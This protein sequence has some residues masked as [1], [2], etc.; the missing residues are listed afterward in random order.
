MTRPTIR[1]AVGITLLFAMQASSSAREVAGLVL[2]LPF[3]E[4]KGA[5]VADG[6]GNGNDGKIKGGVK[7]TT[8]KYGGGLQFDGNDGVVEVPDS[9]SLQFTDGLTVAVWIKP[10][11]KGDEWQLLGSKGADAKEF[12]EVLLSPNGFLWMGWMF[13]NAQRIVP[14]QSPK[15]VKPDVW[16][17]VAVAWDPKQFWTVYLDGEPLI[18]YPKQD[19][20]L[21]PNTDPVLIG[22]ELNLKRY[23]NGVMDDWALFNRGLTQKEIKSV[24]G[25]LDALLPVDPLG[26]SA[27][28][29]GRLKAGR[30]PRA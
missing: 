18:E 1:L 30:G 20:K 14:A 28:T 25:G 19:D 17:H 16:Q 9:K 5:T 27:T 24:M 7:W 4:G 3:G 10:T 21:V 13:Q 12:F 2:A 11:L 6:S 15:E 22:T 29:W 26:R 8:G 23:Y